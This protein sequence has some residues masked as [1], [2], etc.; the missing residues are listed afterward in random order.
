M[1]RLETEDLKSHPRL[2]AFERSICVLRPLRRQARRLW[3]YARWPKFVLHRK[4]VV[5]R[6]TKTGVSFT[7]HVAQ[8]AF[9]TLSAKESPAQAVAAALVE[10]LGLIT[11]FFRRAARRGGPNVIIPDLD[12]LLLGEIS[13]P[14]DQSIR[15]G[16]A[17][18][19]PHPTLRSIRSLTARRSR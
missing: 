8:R 10:Q 19:S 3:L 2:E 5:S 1:V 17:D 15:R 11:C 13:N 14:T 18:R 6:S 16:Q 9:G 12:G 7:N 4:R